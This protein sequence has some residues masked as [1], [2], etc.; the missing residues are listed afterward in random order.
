M[1]NEVA[2]EI[3]LRWGAAVKGRRKERGLL[4]EQLAELAGIDQA[5]VSGIET[6]RYLA[7]LETRI[8]IA[9]ALG[10]THDSLFSVDEVVA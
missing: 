8:A 1:P 6:G 9:K 10:T 2:R 7:S 3:K 5:T 4:Q